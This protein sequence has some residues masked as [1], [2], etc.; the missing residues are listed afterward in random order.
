L[1]LLSGRLAA[2]V[3]WR[4]LWAGEDRLRKLISK[5]PGFERRRTQA[6]VTSLAGIRHTS[7]QAAPAPMPRSAAIGVIGPADG[8][9]TTPVLAE[10]ARFYGLDV[11]RATPECA[12]RVVD[13]AVRQRWPVIGV[14]LEAPAILP[15]QLTDLLRAYVRGG[16]I[17]L[18][19]GILPASS[20]VLAGLSEALGVSLPAGRSVDSPGEVVFTARHIDFSAEFAGVG[21]GAKGHE[22][23][24][25][26][27][28]QAEPL[29]WV[30]SGQRLYPAVSEVRLGRGRVVLCAGTQSITRL[31]DAMAPLQALTVLPAM[32]LVRRAYG[33]AVWR[34][35]ASF[36]NFTIDDPAL[37][38][39]RLGLD[40]GRALALAL[41]HDFHLTIATVPR[42]LALADPSVVA[43]LVRNKPWLSACYHGNDHSGYEFYGPDA[44][45]FRYRA[46]S[47]TAQ[48]KALRRAVARG[49]QFAERS[50]LALDR[51]MV[52][53][54]GV[55]SDE[56]FA[57]MQDLGFLA[58]CN[59]DDRY[60]LGSTLP[61]D[62]YL[63]MR[64]ADVAWQGFPLMWRRGLPDRMFLLDLFLGRPALTFGHLKA[65]GP[66][67]TRFTRRAEEIREIGGGKVRWS[68]LE[69]ISRHSY[70]QRNDPKLGWQVAMT[71]NEIC[72]HNPDALPRIY[73][74]QRPRMPRGYAL[75]TDAAHDSG[76]GELTVTI[77][78]G[79]ARTLTLVGPSSR[80]LSSGQPCSLGRGTNAHRRE[81]EP[82]LRFDAGC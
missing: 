77:P 4:K 42:E 58:T 23:A 20:N 14:A 80:S 59:Y 39:G 27:S 1:T 37:R 62:E 53:P 17:L 60:P 32:M 10:V 36:A 72:L 57:T 13:A 41:E 49:E 79:D 35:P 68:G 81:N 71:S 47:V 6:E 55:G 56:I 2:A 7:G 75:V 63:G 40:Y 44:K 25:E 78:A 30:R 43:L 5:G 76:D 61:Q 19:N 74:M 34:A 3:A 24:L 70:L 29:A 33:E 65:L 11:H 46:R 38:N 9:E 64:P 16:G 54:H 45:G 52:F 8:P 69:D 12:A 18:V 15:P 50:G 48:V 26:A 21:V 22:S 67:L 51:V 82:L 28:D 73:R 31:A 66:D